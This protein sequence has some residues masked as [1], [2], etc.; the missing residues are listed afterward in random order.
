MTISNGWS[1]FGIG[2]SAGV[3]FGE[4]STLV[5]GRLVCGLEDGETVVTEGG[6]HVV[7]VVVFVL[8]VVVHL[9]EYFV[10]PAPVAG[11][12]AVR[13]ILAALGKDDLHL[14]LASAP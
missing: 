2:L 5:E 13:V 14:V 12:F 7:P 3:E 6:H 10:V 8:A 11:S 1:R 9:L 4:R